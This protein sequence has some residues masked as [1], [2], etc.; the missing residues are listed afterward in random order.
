M[1]T[2]RNVEL[3]AGAR[4]LLSGADLQIGP[5]DRIGLVG[6]NGA[7]KTT[8][9]RVL[10]GETGPA[11]G[12]VSRT[13]TPGYLPQD[14]TAADPAQAVRARI[15]AA[16]GLD[17]VQARMQ[18]AESRMALVDEAAR[19]RAMRSYARAEEEFV[20]AGGYAAAAEAA[21]VAAG[22]GV[23]TTMLDRPMG[24]LSGGQRRR[25]ELARL[26]FGESRTLLLDEPT[27][28][29]DG[30][31]IRWLRQFLADHNGG[32]LVISHDV[33]LLDA[34][35]NKV[36]HLDSERCELDLYQLGWTAYLKAHAGEQARRRREKANADRTARTLVTQAEKMR[37]KATKA[38]AAQQML[39][40]AER[41]QSAHQGPD[42]REKVAALR[43]PEPVPCGRVPLT[44]EGL[45]K[46]YGSAEV[47]AGVSLAVDRGARVAVIGL[48]GAGKTTLLRILAGVELSDTGSVSAGHGLRT[49]Y[50]AQEHETLDTGS[51]VFENLQRAAPDLPEQQVRDVLGSF[52]FSG[53]RAQQLA[54]TLSGGERTRLVLATL[55]VSGANVL[56]LDEPTNNL[57]PLSRDQVLAALRA[58]PGAVVLVT[59]DVG[60]ADALAPERVIV[61]PDGDEDMWN[62][63][64]RELVALA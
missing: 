56:L 26:L 14:P 7:G 28:H 43:F 47:F 21:S 29:L 46:S 39:R 52:M 25:V 57:D 15:L 30:D 41:L 49:G 6:R 1:I 54:G 45:S 16:R 62:D 8:L 19:D 38:R 58:Y 34:V 18:R 31:S 44:A 5:G 32:L 9:M 51:T 24:E 33:D 40:R 4:L 10:A 60:A 63:G 3:R 20:A 37:A 2:A 22:L 27:N 64:Y 35:V 61:L 36:A 11:A 13:G 48:N 59:H 23:S 12:E 17:E 50:Y 53:E 55:V 42:S